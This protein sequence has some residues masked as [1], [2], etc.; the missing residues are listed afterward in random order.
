M[1]FIVIWSGGYE[2]PSIAMRH[3]LKEAKI[4]ARGWR[5]DAAEEDSVEIYRIDVPAS[6]V[7]HIE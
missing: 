5:L 6:L 7:E 2:L 1:V 3:T 4:L